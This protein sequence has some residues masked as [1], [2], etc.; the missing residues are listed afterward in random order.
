MRLIPLEQG[1]FARERDAVPRHLVECCPALLSELGY[2][3]L[4]VL[5]FRFE[6]VDLLANVRLG[7]RP[8]G[9]RLSWLG[10]FSQ[11]REAVPQR[12]QRLRMPAYGFN[13]PVREWGGYGRGLPY[14]GGRVDV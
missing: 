1:D 3:V 10:R 13:V 6:R 12:T 7:Q 2:V 8:R 11:R 14:A 5:A 4:R 9:L